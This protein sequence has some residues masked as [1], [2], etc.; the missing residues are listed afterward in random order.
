[1]MQPMQTDALTSLADPSAA[2]ARLTPHEAAEFQAGAERIAGAV[3]GFMQ[4]KADVV[5]LAL[6]CLL[7]EGH[8]LLEDVPGVGKTSL[9]RCLAGALGI[10][11]QRIQFTPD[12][13]P[14]DVTGVSVFHQDA[15]DFVFHKGPVFANVVLAD[16][17]NR[18]SPR[19]QSA[20]LE[21]ME[22]RTVT[23]D[24]RSYPVPR[25]FMVMATQNPVEMDGTYP[26]PEAQLDRF[27]IKTAVGYP[28]PASE[29]RMLTA[30]HGGAEIGEV[31]PVSSAEEVQR[32]VAAARTVHVSPA[33]I[34]YIVSIVSR[35][36][37]VSALRLGA[38]P[39]GAIGLLRA[40]RV[41]AALEG[42]TFVVPSDIQALARP[43][44]A[45]RVL[46][47]SGNSSGLAAEE[48]IEDVVASVE[49]PPSARLQ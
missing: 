32:L 30:A 16:E 4:G 15:N 40:G 37:A 5:R 47:A 46:L 42:R 20:L 44:L 8:L 11:W 29:A 26:L 9:A 10:P 6:L 31:A 49:A 48:A 27:L 33:V 18:A 21:V 7:A 25:P 17:V 39:R 45:H 34:D 28:D 23:V 38:S 12:L 3:N 43:V 13:L 41:T 2:D 19:T 22:E 1:M 14:G 36:R 24:G 35:T